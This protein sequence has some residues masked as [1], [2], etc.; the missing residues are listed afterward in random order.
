M[1]R[2][3]RQAQAD[4]DK[5]LVDKHR[6][7]DKRPGKAKK[8]ASLDAR[9]SA[10]I[11]YTSQDD[12]SKMKVSDLD[13][14]LCW[15]RRFDEQVSRA[16]DMPTTKQEKLHLVWEVVERYTTGLVRPDDD[17]LGMM[18]NLKC[19]GHAI[20]ESSREMAETDPEDEIE[21]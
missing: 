15:H 1:E 21:V 2:K 11:P 7:D 3:H 17:P 20:I 8:K 10:Y 14:Q 6:L 18:G 5:Q 12:L 16:K 9:F 4:H 19:E 13:F